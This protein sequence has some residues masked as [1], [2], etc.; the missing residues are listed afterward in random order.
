MESFFLKYGMTK[1]QKLSFQKG[2]EKI[3]KF[4]DQAS[5]SFDQT[6]MY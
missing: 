5:R 1:N 4:I 3:K 6:A 2:Y